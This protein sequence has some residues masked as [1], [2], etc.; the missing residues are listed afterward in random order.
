MYN[1]DRWAIWLMVCLHL[2]NPIAP[3]KWYVEMKIND[4]FTCKTYLVVTHWICLCET[5]PMSY[6]KIWFGEN[7]I[8]YI[9]ISG[10]KWSLT[11]VV[12]LTSKGQPAVHEMAMFTIAY[13][14]LTLVYWY[15]DTIHYGLKGCWVRISKFWMMFRLMKSDEMV[16]F[17]IY[18][19]AYVDQFH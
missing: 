4:K 6:C 9:I 7:M 13:T 18:I 14:I 2:N 15:I 12:K 19:F 11:P 1:N 8:C 10:P 17:F 3:E 5:N 16:F